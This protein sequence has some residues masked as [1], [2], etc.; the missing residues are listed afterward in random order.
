MLAI[1][2]SRAT[3]RGERIPIGLHGESAIRTAVSTRS[4]DLESV[5]SP[6][7]SPDGMSR[8]GRGGE[9]TSI[10]PVDRQDDL[11]TERG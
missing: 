1:S 9:V 8:P 5:Q 3:S 7:L 6:P 2:S 10:R 11:C 4:A